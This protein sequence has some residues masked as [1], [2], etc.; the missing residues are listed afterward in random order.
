[1]PFRASFDC[2]WCGRPHTARGDGDLEGWAQL[3]PDCVGRAQ[4][5]E[6]LR[7]RVR[8]A[9]AERTRALA[10]SGANVPVAAATTVDAP[11]ASDIDDWY[12]RQGRHSQGPIQDQVWHAELD[13][14]TAWLDRLPWRGELV[15]LA[16]GVG[17]WSPLLAQKGELSLYDQSESALD[18]AR[19][20][21]VAHGLKAHLHVRD[22]WAEPDRQVDGLFTARWLSRLGPAELPRFL[23]LA[24]WWLKPGGLYAFI[25]EAAGGI[26]SDALGQALLEARFQAVE[27]SSTGRFLIM[28]RGSG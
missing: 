15:E 12:R 18:R 21:L 17:W 2:L 8:A 13:T 16:A 6:F 7:Y 4:E 22:P 20:R 23:G 11:S 9:L 10:P 24:K 5:N 1:M 28:G 25:D 3:C 14:A 19:E 27:T 26:D